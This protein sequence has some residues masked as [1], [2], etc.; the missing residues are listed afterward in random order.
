MWVLFQALGLD[1]SIVQHLGTSKP[2][3]WA[4]GLSS[5]L[6]IPNKQIEKLHNSGSQASNKFFICQ[7]LGFPLYMNNGLGSSYM[8]KGK[9]KYLQTYVGDTIVSY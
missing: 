8:F 4:N 6:Y 5:I 1:I 3:S 9:L 7:A 2:A